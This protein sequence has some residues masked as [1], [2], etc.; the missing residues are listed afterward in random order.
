MSSKD[1]TATAPPPA[2][3]LWVVHSTTH[4]DADNLQSQ[5]RFHT[6][7]CTFGRTADT[8]RTREYKAAMVSDL[9]AEGALVDPNSIPA[10][11]QEYI[12]VME[13]GQQRT[14]RWI[15]SHFKLAPD[16]WLVAR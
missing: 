1:S 9:T 5:L 12:A 4:Y 16:A 8:T 2:A 11:P 3:D 15:T 7:S 14:L 13:V 10:W 6:I